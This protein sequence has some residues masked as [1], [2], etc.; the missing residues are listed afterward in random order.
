V[1]DLGLLAVLASMALS[2]AATAATIADTEEALPHPHSRLILSGTPETQRS[3]SADERDRKWW[4]YGLVGAGACGVAGGIVG[5]FAATHSCTDYALPTDVAAGA[6]DFE[7]GP[8]CV[9]HRHTVEG[10][11][12]GS[13]IGAAAGILIGLREDQLSE[14]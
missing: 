14:D 7:M 3:R 4:R 5:Y 13:G 1:T 8:G 12:I 2:G 9:T 10:A 11:L 6:A